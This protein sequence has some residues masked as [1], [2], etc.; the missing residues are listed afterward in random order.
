MLRVWKFL[1][2]LVGLVGISLAQEDVLVKTPLTKRLQDMNISLGV[3]SIEELKQVFPRAYELLVKKEGPPTKYDTH[4]VA[5]ALWK[6]EGG[7]V[8]YLSGY[9]VE[10]EVRSHLL[11]SQRKSAHK[12]PH[13]Y[14][15]NY[16]A[17]FQMAEKGLYSINVYIKEPKTGKVRKVNFDYLLQ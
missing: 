14:G 12:Y 15:E 9:D 16:G 7:K 1:L 3:V 5:V 11:R 2:L 17:W 10:I 13:Q 8:S 6:E 4:H